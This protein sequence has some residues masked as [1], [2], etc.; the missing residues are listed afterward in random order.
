MGGEAF[1]FAEFFCFFGCLYT[2]CILCSYLAIYLLIYK[3]KRYRY[4]LSMIKSYSYGKCKNDWEL[5]LW[6]MQTRY[7]LF[8]G[9]GCWNPTLI[10]SFNDWELELVERLLFTLWGLESGCGEG[11]YCSV[12]VGWVLRMELSVSGS[13]IGL[14]NRDLTL[15]FLGRAFGGE[16]CSR[17]CASSCGR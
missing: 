11:K 3:K 9:K 10:R 15:L 4:R 8:Q 2:S 13:C 12:G 6:E 7:R 17:N 16:G 1:C 5:F 14:W